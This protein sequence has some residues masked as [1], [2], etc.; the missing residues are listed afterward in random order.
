MSARETERTIGPDI[1]SHDT[2]GRL[3]SARSR[4]IRRNVGRPLAAAERL[5]M[6]RSALALIIL[7]AACGDNGKPAE[8]KTDPKVAVA[9]APKAPAFDKIARVD[10]NRIAQE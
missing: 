4:M 3:T 8:T 7:V 1:A 10:F 2:Q 6:H 9:E 5:F